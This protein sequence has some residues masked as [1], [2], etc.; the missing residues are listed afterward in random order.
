MQYALPVAV[1]PWVTVVNL[2]LAKAAGFAVP[3]REA[4]D[5]DAF[6]RGAAAMHQ[7]PN[8]EGPR[9]TVGVGIDVEPLWMA[10]DQLWNDAPSFVF[11]QSTLG[12]LPDGQGS[13]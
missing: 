2:D 9:P 13:F 7:S 8:V 6:V 4:W 3:P 1:A 11:L 10:P 5:A 12:A